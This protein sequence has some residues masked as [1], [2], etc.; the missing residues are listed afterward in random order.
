MFYTG[1]VLWYDE[2]DGKEVEHGFFLEANNYSKAMEKLK[3]Y[4]GETE[5]IKISVEAFSSDTILITTNIG[6]YDC[7][8]KEF[9]DNVCW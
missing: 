8:K 1:K 2:V 4:F 5:M 7:I 6:I 9:E 3:K